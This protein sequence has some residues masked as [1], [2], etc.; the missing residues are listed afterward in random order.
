M[1]DGRA[2]G[3]VERDDGRA[4]VLGEGREGVVVA[5]HEETHVGLGRERVDEQVAE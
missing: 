4:R 2:A 5:A 3:R 1:D